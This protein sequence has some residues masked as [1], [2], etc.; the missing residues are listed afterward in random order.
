MNG[1]T[2]P[3]VFAADL[4][5]EQQR[6]VRASMNVCGPPRLPVLAR[7]ASPVRSREDDGTRLLLGANPDD[8]GFAPGRKRRARSESNPTIMQVG[9][10]RAGSAVAST[11]RRVRAAQ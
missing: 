3:G 1:A 10:P 4:L 6:L 9:P 7:S 5:Q 11:A 8:A 2:N